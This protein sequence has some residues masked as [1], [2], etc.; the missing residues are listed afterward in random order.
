M[1]LII[2]RGVAFVP[3]DVSEYRCMEVDFDEDL[4]KAQELFC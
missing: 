1:E 4:Q 3:I 2:E